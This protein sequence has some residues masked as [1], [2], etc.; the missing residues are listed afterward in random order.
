[1]VRMRAETPA[2]SKSCNRV[3]EDAIGRILRI[4]G[5]GIVLAALSV[6]AATAQQ[7]DPRVVTFKLPGQIVWKDN[8]KG[9]NR[10]AV[11]QGDASKP[12]PYAMLLQWLPG[13][14]SRPHFHPNDRFFIVISGT[15][16]VG[17]GPKFDPGAT[18][19]VPAG[20]FVTRL[21][22]GVHFDGAKDEQ[23]TILVWGEG[24]ATSM[25]FGE[26]PPK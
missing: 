1:M 13:N 7:L 6:V 19:P 9:G 12:G 17:S 11:L 14:M 24:P 25:P 21:A 4:A 15:W 16:W 5:A 23:A 10:S 2:G 8:P 20:S 26:P 22:N 3:W 18:V